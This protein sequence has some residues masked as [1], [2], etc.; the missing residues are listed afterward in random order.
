[1]SDNPLRSIGAHFTVALLAA[2]I[3][4]AG[5]LFARAAVVAADIAEARVTAPIVVR[6]QQPADWAT[7]GRAA[8]ILQQTDGV[9]FAAPMSPERAEA[10]LRSAGSSVNASQL[11]SFYIV[12]AAVERRFGDPKAGVIALLAKQ[13]IAAEVDAPPLA[14]GPPIREA[15]WG[16]G[17]LIGLLGLSLIWLSAR[18][19]AQVAAAAAVINADIG[20]PLSRT[21]RAYGRSGAT[22]GFRAGVM[23]AVAA[24]GCAAAAI[25]S[26]R[27]GPTLDDLWP[28]L[29]RV[30]FAMLFLAPLMM[31]LAAASGARAGGADTHRRAERIG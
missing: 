10:L 14:P 13:G 7:V 3:A 4:T 20:A 21:L 25:M 24:A 2:F 17:L 15:A 5:A 1:M 27:G 26:P 6:L 18:A 22:F 29:G 23:G 31:A 28:L 9:S 16:G 19:Q 8:Q 11:P 12:E 30:E